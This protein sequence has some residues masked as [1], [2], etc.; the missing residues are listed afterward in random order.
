MKKT[1]AGIGI[2]FFFLI[3]LITAGWENTC[4]KVAI[5]VDRLRTENVLQK[6][7]GRISIHNSHHKY[8]RSLITITAE[9]NSYVP[10]KIPKNTC[11]DP[12]NTKV[13]VFRKCSDRDLFTD[14]HLS[15][16]DDY[17]VSQTQR[18]PPCSRLS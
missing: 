3:F 8:R 2:I 6:Y 14:F 11:S 16:K 1:F 17:A 15:L 13:S 7:K 9:K 4:T 18:G 12:L 5:S 10:S